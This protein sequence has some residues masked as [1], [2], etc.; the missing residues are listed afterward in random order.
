MGEEA[1][2]LYHEQYRSKK[3][4][5]RDWTWMRPLRMTSSGLTKL[6]GE[7]EDRVLLGKVTEL[8]T[9]GESS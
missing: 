4:R 8:T 2:K 3:I 6:K 1:I 5:K 7:T 9:I